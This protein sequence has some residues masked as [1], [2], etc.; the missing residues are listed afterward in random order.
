[1]PLLARVIV[2]PWLCLLPPF[3]ILALNV[4]HWG[5]VSNWEIYR[6]YLLWG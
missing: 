6:V 3:P 2:M 1:M 4:L 5:M